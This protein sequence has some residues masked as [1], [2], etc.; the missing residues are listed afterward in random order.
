MTPRIPKLIVT[1]VSPFLVATSCF[2]PAADCAGS[3]QVNTTT[4][5]FLGSDDFEGCWLP[6]SS[7]AATGGEAIYN[8][9]FVFVNIDMNTVA[10]VLPANLTLAPQKSMA[11]DVHPVLLL[12]GHQTA[13]KWVIG[14]SEIPIGNDYQELA[15]LIPFVQRKDKPFWH[16]YVVRM[17]LNDG[18]ARDIGNWFFGYAKKDATFSATATHETVSASATPVYTTTM[19]PTGTWQSAETSGAT[20]YSDMK[21]ILDMPILGV[22]G[23]GQFVCSY[24]EMDYSGAS[25]EVRTINSR[26]QFLSPFTTGM[27]LWPAL[28][29]LSNVADGAMEVKTIEWRIASPPAPPCAF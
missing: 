20:N 5:A 23:T 19:T 2:P 9:R 26:Q 25:A 6:R 16:N 18:A 17:Y 4:S 10:N 22:L 11:P 28:G 15:L 13:T 29:E 8:G 1:F 27:A 12:F 24:F 7:D 3:G 14:G 21:T